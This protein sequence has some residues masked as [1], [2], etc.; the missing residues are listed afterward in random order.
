MQRIASDVPDGIWAS[1]VSSVC[2][3]FVP[4][5]F[6]ADKD[7]A[8]VSRFQ[9]D[10]Q[11]ILIDYCYR[12]HAE[13]AKKGGVTFDQFVSDESML[14]K[15]DLWSAVLKNVRAGIMPPAEKPHPSDKELQLLAGW[16]KRD[17]FGLDPE[18]P[19]PRVV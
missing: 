8:A 2:C 14:G 12:C 1:R 10:I 7:I 3:Q 11:P 17:V 13:G 4:A 18:R 16:I 6:G 15:R 9:E 5:S 19:R